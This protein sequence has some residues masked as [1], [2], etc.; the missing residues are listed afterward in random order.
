MDFPIHYFP[1]QFGFH[2]HQCTGSIDYWA[3]LGFV[4]I[5]ASNFS[6]GQSLLPITNIYFKPEPH[7]SYSPAQ[8]LF[9]G[10]LLPRGNPNI[11]SLHSSSFIT[12]PKQP[13][14]TL[15]IAQAKILI[16]SQ[17]GWLAISK[18]SSTLP[19]SKILSLI[20]PFPRMVLHA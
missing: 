1:N 12:C 6:L 10:S 2:N 7:L 18:T 9:C 15:C 13:W 4:G 5:S 8:Q 17:M 3:I 11:H 16:S 20:C 19:G 14:E